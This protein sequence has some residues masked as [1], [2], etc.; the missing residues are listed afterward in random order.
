MDNVFLIVIT[1]FIIAVFLFFVTFVIT[2]RKTSKKYKEKVTELDI[3]KNQLI[4]VKILSEITKVRSLV[5]TDNLKH[6]LDDWDHTFNYIKDEMLPSITD[7]I[8]EVDFMIDKHDY[9][10]A[11]KKM[12]AIELEIDKLKRKSKKLIEE[13]QIIT[14]SEERNRALITKLKV[15]YRELQGKFNRCEKEYGELKPK[16]Q[17]Q[18]D[19]IDELFLSFESAMENNDYVEV[20]K[21]V[22]IIEDEL[23][24]LKDILDNIPSLL[25]MASVLI[26]G[27]IEEAKV[28]YGRMQ[29]DGYP[30]DYLNVEYNLDEIKK[31]TDGIMENIRELKMEDANI[32]LKTILDYFSSLFSDFDK[33]RECKDSFKEGCKKFRYKLEKVNKVVYDIYVQ[34]DDIKV[35]YDLTDEEINRFSLLNRNLETINE[36]FKMLLEH[37]KTKIFAYSKLYDE[38][39]GLEIKLSRLQ[40]DLDYQLKS[41]TSMQDDEYRAKEQLNTIQDLL[42]KAKM[43]LKDYKLPVIPSSYYVELKEAQDAIRE[44]VK[45][46]DK[47]P[48]VIKILNIRVDT[49]RDLVFKIYNKTNDMI[50]ASQLSEKMIIYGNRYRSTYQEVDQGLERATMLFYKGQYEQSLE[51]SMNAIKLVEENP[52]DK[53]R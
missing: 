7:E 20:E 27:K 34:I 12:T 39:D 52:L 37:G 18:F 17:E 33:E 46:L 47:K 48:I 35:T 15:M 28:L 51:Q 11:I 21:I 40:D 22:I 26:P 41:I 8:S 32:E 14:N 9:K 25:L 16:I 49:A 31:K 43:K 1:T 30:M 24:N 6:K 3:E 42:K 2:R 29:R 50:K 38:L 10:G 36:D 53:I 45:E 13:I 23:T 4:N 19:K 44:I 5:K